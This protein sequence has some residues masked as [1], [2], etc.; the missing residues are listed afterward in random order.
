MG[1]TQVLRQTLLVAVGVA[2]LRA[3]Q[4]LELQ[5]LAAVVA[6]GMTAVLVLQA[7]RA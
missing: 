3:M 4:Q 6:V 7:V 2:A 1:L 5:T